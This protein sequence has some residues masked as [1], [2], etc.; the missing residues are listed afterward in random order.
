MPADQFARGNPQAM[1]RDLVNNNTYILPFDG[2]P[3][4][5]TSGTFAGFA[6]PGTLLLDFTN[7]VAYINTNTQASP[8]WDNLQAILAGDIA[9]AEGNVLVG[10]AGGIAVA[11]DPSAGGNIIVGNDTTMV[12]LDASLDTRILVGDGTTIASVLM[13]GDATL[14][15]TGTLSLA[16]ALLGNAVGLGTLRVARAVFDPATNAGERTVAAHTLAVT[17]PDNAVIVGGFIDVIST[18]SSPTA[19]TAT[20]AISVEAA[21]D[22]VVAVAIATGTPWDAGQQ[23]ILPKANTPESTAVKTTA[24]RLITATVAVE[25][26]TGTGKAEIYLY[27]VQSS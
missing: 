13:S 7:G 26:L 9:L 5:G 22:I 1:I 27:Y 15:N 19:D 4:N 16:P 12:A 6:G 8:T 11:L 2:A 24:A 23:A 21:D 17:I 14:A 10:N 20:I 25:A 3:T 18:F